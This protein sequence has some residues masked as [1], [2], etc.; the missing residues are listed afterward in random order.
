MRRYVSERELIP[1]VSNGRNEENDKK[2]TNKNR[3]LVILGNKSDRGS[4]LKNFLATG[5]EKK[6]SKYSYYKFKVLLSN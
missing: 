5:S 4:N 2:K 6:N 1:A 3:K